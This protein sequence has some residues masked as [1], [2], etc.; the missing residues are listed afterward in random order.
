ML[1]AESYLKKSLVILAALAGLWLGMFFPTPALAHKVYVYA[2]VEGDRV[3]V[4]GYFNRSQ[5]AQGSLVE[6]FG[7]DGRK[8]LE[9]KTDEKGLFSFKIPQKTDLKIVLTASMGHKSDY[10]LKADELAGGGSTSRPT[11]APASKPEAQR[12]AEPAGQPAQAVR[13]SVPAP[14]VSQIDGD[15]LRAMIDEAL[16]RK[17]EPLI[18]AM[19]QANEPHGPGLTEILGGLG[20]ILGLLGIVMYMKSRAKP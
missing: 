14:A 19:A 12:A 13:P 20:Y 10:T 18:R 9:G 16:D 11:L 15:R 2:W 17:L 8:L 4:E 5:K 6:V 7:P 1:S 3:Q